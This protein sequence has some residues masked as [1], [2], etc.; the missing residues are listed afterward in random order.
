M[1][2]KTPT[3]LSDL[4]AALRTELEVLS[5]EVSFLRTDLDRA[6]LSQLRDRVTKLESILQA[7]NVPSLLVQLGV[8]QEQLGELKKWRD[9]MGRRVMQVGLLFGGSLLTLAIQLII[10]FLKK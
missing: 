1:A 3:E 10:L 4:I 2:G 9:E 7:V 8:I 6:E 5:R